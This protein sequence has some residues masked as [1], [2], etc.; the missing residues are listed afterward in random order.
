MVPMT[1]GFLLSL[2]PIFHLTMPERQF[3]LMN[4]NMFSGN[5]PRPAKKIEK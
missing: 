5:R 3:Q 2:L 1:L 4:R